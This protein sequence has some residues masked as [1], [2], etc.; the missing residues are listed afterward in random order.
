MHR[1]GE[2]MFHETNLIDTG[3]DDLIYCH[4]LIKARSDGSMNF[5]TGDSGGAA[6]LKETASGSWPASITS[7][8]DLL[9]QHASGGTA[10]WRLVRYSRLFTTEG[11]TRPHYTLI[12]RTR[13]RSNRILF[14]PDFI[15]ARV[16]L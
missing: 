7:V 13:S 16:D 9:Y 1:W 8:D 6:F 10:S 12:H 5:S 3:D 15:E 11:V 4:A 14:D 2:N